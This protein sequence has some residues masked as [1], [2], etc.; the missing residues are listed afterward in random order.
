[1]ILSPSVKETQKGWE[2]LPEKTLKRN[3]YPLNCIGSLPKI[4]M[5]RAGQP[6]GM[7]SMTAL[8]GFGGRNFRP[9]RVK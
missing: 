4:T 9:F 2:V 1:M 5:Q 3:L 6:I 7:T 8:Q